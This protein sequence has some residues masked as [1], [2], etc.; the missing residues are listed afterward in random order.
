MN[1]MQRGDQPTL[2]RFTNRAF[3]RI[4]V[5]ITLTAIVVSGCGK[6]TLS[7]DAYHLVGALDRIFEKRDPQQLKLASD[8]IHEELAAG[9]I[10]NDEASILNALIAKAHNEDWESACSDAR[11]LLSDQTDW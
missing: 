2:L 1:D 3:K 7:T 10:T 4:A 9:K 6:T 11:K 5:G 8:K